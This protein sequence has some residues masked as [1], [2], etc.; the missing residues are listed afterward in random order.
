MKKYLRSILMILFLVFFG[1]TYG[2]EKIVTGLVTDK[3]NVPLPSV[4]IL[5][6]GTTKGVQ[7]DFDGNFSI[8][9][10]PDATLVVS[11]MGF[12]TKEVTVGSLEQI[13]IVLEDD[14]A[15]LDEI[16]IVGYGTVKKSDLTGSVSSVSAK[17]INAI[18]VSSIDQALQGRASGV[19]VIQNSGIPGSPTTIRIR[20]INSISGGNRPLV[21]VDGFPVIGGLENINPT[22]IENIEILKDA[23]STAIYG[24]RGTNGVIIVTTKKGKDG[25][26]TIDFDSYSGI[27]EQSKKLDLLNAQQFAQVANERAVNDGETEL[28]FPN[29]SAITADTDWIDELFDTA[30]MQSHTITLTAGNDRVKTSQSFNYFDQ[31]G[32]LKNSGFTRAT[33]RN[34]TEVK[35]SDWLT[36]ANSMI[37]SRSD[38]K[39]SGDGGNRAVL[40]A[41]LAS[42][43][44]P[45]YD[46]DGNYSDVTTNTYSGLNY[47]PG[48]LDNP[49]KWINEYDDRIFTTKIFDNFY[50]LFTLTPNLTF[51]SSIGVDYSTTQTRRYLSRLLLDGAPGGKA[52][53]GSTESYSILN[54][55]I[56]N[57]NKEFGNHSVNAI[58]GYNWQTFKSTFISASSTDFVTDLLG[59]EVLQD[60]AIPQTP[61]SGNTEWG[62][63]SLLGRVNYSYKGKYLV[64]LTARSDWSSRFAK[65]KQR[66]TFPSAAVAWKLSNEDFMENVSWL[67]DL[68]LRA[69]WGVT[70]NQAVSPFQTWSSVQS[71]PVVLGGALG[72]GFVPGAP[73]NPDLKWETTEQYDFGLDFGVLNN[74]VQF[75]MDYYYKK[76]TDLLAQVDLPSSVG[77]SSITQNIG[78]M[79]NKGIEISVDANII[80]SNNISWDASFQ[81]SRNRNKVLKLNNGADV[82]PG[83]VNNLISS[84]HIIRE[85]LPLST[86]YGF[87]NDGYDSAG[88]NQYLD[89]AG[90]DANDNLVMQPDGQVNDD[91]RRV[92]GNP[93]PDF[94]FGFGNTFKYKN[95]S[96]NVFV[97][98]AQGFDIVWGTKFQLK[99]SFSRGGN[100]LTEVLNHWTPS[101]TTNA[102][103]PIISDS[104]SFRGST[105]F[106]EDGS[107]IKIRTI[108][109]T[110]DIP[111]DKISWLNNAQ[112]Y[113]NA[114]NMFTFTNYSGYDPEVKAYGDG[115]LRLGVDNNVYPST[116]VISMGLR[117]GI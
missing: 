15:R 65:G 98:G 103:S 39:F 95:F 68:K 11:S 70:G 78:E 88:Q 81:F 101:N 27:Q 71:A 26:F 49:M 46:A 31:D 4:N 23:S 10:G 14:I 80:N 38:R 53:R 108:N 99:N 113:I 58:V 8:I 97:E 94:T 2:Q 82:F 115:D 60:G 19:S 72:V 47:A 112:I 30:L 7:T 25:R 36:V 52:F 9:T 43:T 102:T 22:D 50:G 57:Y 56:F 33:L 107:Y 89:F 41:H 42:P 5:V 17:D 104:S 84:F 51:K 110:Y 20:G 54:E 6:K 79:E 24:A 64:T 35:M 114:Q 13:T 116:K 55:N 61:R 76:T 73:D 67:S 29:P 117:V 3:L 111:T 62:L 16:V 45:V 100:Q 21:I 63:A 92:I 66:A 18:P 83:S 109:L 69:S 74:R 105:E 37:L 87:V 91:D 106:I 75:T 93:H 34:N 85:G 44:I 12:I 1:K 86:F 90:R 32:I 28:F 40:E 48:A 59:A 77:F 96:L